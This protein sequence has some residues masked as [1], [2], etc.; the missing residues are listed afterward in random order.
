MGEGDGVGL[1]EGVGGRVDVGEVVEPS[2]EDTAGGETCNSK[3]VFV[4]VK[5]VE[6]GDGEGGGT[7]ASGAASVEVGGIAGE[8]PPTT[9][10]TPPPIIAIASDVARTAVA[11]VPRVGRASKRRGRRG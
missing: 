1:A 11:Q 8:G 3:G 5:E 6:E 10:H 4:A 9:S 7:A 2:G